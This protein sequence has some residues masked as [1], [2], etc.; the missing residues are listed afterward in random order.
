MPAIKSSLS[1][2]WSRVQNQNPNRTSE[3]DDSCPEKTTKRTQELPPHAR[4]TYGDPLGAR[5]N[6]RSAAC[7]GPRILH[8]RSIARSTLE[9][10]PPWRLSRNCANEPKPTNYTNDFCPRLM[11]P[12][13]SVLRPLHVRPVLGHHHHPRADADMGRDHG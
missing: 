6:P 2:L 11:T 4:G 13:V 8:E 7:I 9:P 1:T 10:E 12:S 3:P 5:S